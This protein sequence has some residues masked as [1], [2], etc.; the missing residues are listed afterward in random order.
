MNKNQSFVVFCLLLFFS[1]ISHANSTIIFTCSWNNEKPIN[2]VVNTDNNSASRSD[3]ENFYKVIKITNLAVWLMVNEPTTKNGISIHM[4]QRA[5]TVN[6][7]AGKW[8]D[9]ISNSKGNVT[10]INGGICWEK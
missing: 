9:I 2:I 7:K 1:F 10:P 4:I 8:I 5:D 3:I 6:G